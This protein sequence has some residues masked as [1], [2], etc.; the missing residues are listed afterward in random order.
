MITSQYNDDWG[1]LSQLT[2]N[3]PYS[4]EEVYTALENEEYQGTDSRR[5]CFEVKSSI[6]QLIRKT[7]VDYVPALLEEISKF[8]EFVEHWGLDDITELVNNVKTSCYF[9]C[10]KPGYTTGL[11]IDCKSQVCTGMLF[12]NQLDDPDQ[13]TYFSPSPNGDNPVRISSEY[14]NGWFSANTYNG[15]HIGANNTLRDRYALI[16]VNKLNLK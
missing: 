13:S 5:C 4:Q 6:L 11:H 12:F 10:D 3:F 7:V 2:T 14:G 8:P 1:L 15:Y 16:F 9:V